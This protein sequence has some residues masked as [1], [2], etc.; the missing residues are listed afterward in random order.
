MAFYEEEGFKLQLFARSK[1]WEPAEKVTTNTTIRRVAEL[2]KAETGVGTNIADIVLISKAKV[3]QHNKTLGYYGIT[4]ERHLIT[5]QFKAR[6][7][8][9]VNGTKI[10]LSNK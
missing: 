4:N 3:M 6:G 9:F 5:M 7:G 8:C 2:Y 10:L 1:Y